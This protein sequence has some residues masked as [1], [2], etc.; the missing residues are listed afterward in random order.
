MLR[1]SGGWTKYNSLPRRTLPP[2]LCIVHT[3]TVGGMKGAR[4]G[5]LLVV[6]FKTAITVEMKTEQERTIALGVVGIRQ[7]THRT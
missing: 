7:R 5:F 3:E 4:R 1:Q 2:L 6:A